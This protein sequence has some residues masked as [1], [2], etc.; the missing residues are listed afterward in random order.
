MGPTVSLVEL[1]THETTPG[2]IFKIVKMI[3]VLTHTVWH[4]NRKYVPSL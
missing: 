1:K 4:L 3:K 2:A